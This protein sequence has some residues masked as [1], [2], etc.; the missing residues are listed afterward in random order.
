MSVLLLSV[1]DPSPVSVSLYLCIQ[2]ASGAPHISTPSVQT[3]ALP[4]QSA[5]HVAR[6]A[7][8]PIVPDPT[9]GLSQANSQTGHFV[10]TAFVVHPHS[11]TNR[12]NPLNGPRCDTCVDVNSS[13]PR[14]ISSQNLIA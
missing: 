1:S 12:P 3:I 8:K 10:A 11:T 9:S 7:F 2:L 13:P 4:H 6:Y 14:H 5:P